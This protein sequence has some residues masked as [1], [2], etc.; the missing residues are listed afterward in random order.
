MTVKI[1][2]KSPIPQRVHVQPP[3]QHGFSVKVNKKG[4]IAAGMSE[5]IQVTFMSDVYKYQYDVIKINS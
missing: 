4:P 3:T 1:I 2:N 5:N